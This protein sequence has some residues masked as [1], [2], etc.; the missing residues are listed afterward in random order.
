MMEERIVVMV[1]EVAELVEET[2]EGAFRL[3]EGLRRFR[4]LGRARGVRLLPVSQDEEG[5][6]R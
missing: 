3:A 4:A 2:P 5:G 6:G 1:D